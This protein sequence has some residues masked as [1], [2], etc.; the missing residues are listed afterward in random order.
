MSSSGEFPRVDVAVVG[1]GPAGSTT[2]LTLARRGWRVV[3]VDRCRPRAQ[4]I[5]ETLPPA[6]KSTLKHLGVWSGFV[7]DSCVASPGIVAWWDG[8]D[9]LERDFIMSPFGAEWHVDRACFDRVLAARATDAGAEFVAVDRPVGASIAGAGTRDERWRIRFASGGRLC[10]ISARFVVNASGRS[11]SF[12]PPGSERRRIDRL[13]GLAAVFESSACHVD[14]RT[15]IEATKAGWWYS[16]PGVDGR[17]TVVHFT[18]ANLLE[19]TASTTS[20]ASWA[21]ALDH[22][23]NT[24]ERVRQLGISPDDGAPDV[25][26]LAA[27]SYVTARCQGTRWLAVGDAASAW[28]PL[29]GQG[30]ERALRAG[31]RAGETIEAFLTGDAG[32]LEDYQAAQ[33]A[34]DEDY[35]VRRRD[36]YGRVDRWNHEEFWRRRLQPSG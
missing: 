13:I 11:M 28:D 31:I 30:I 20:A 18:D 23:P 14:R 9:P 17:W 32:A 33:R 4:R 34:L 3:V 1:A 24:A 2:A 19:R 25:Q 15:W 7:A 27:G 29:S 10:E 6:S 8:V 35:L 36:C 5:V 26:V 16:A 12:R 21:R 22:G